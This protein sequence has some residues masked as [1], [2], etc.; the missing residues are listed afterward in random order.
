MTTKKWVS[1]EIDRR[2]VD[3]VH[4]V[5]IWGLNGLWREDGA[6]IGDTLAAGG[7]GKME[8]LSCKT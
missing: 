2:L 6:W 1:L 3:A 5:R 7:T 8:D 4:R